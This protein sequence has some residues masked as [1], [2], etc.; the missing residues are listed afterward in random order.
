MS[1]I[2]Y[3]AWTKLKGTRLQQDAGIT[4]IEEAIPIM[5]DSTTHHRMMVQA[6]FAVKIACETSNEVLQKAIAKKFEEIDK[7]ILAQQ[8]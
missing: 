6:I 3:K 7:L 5:R 1:M 2:Q 4:A 8:S